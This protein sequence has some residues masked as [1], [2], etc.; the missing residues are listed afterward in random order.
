MTRFAL[1]CAALLF[2]AACD[3]DDG[4]ETTA[5]G[6]SGAASSTTDDPSTSGDDTTSTTDAPTTGGSSSGGAEGSSSGGADGSSSGG[7]SSTGEPIACDPP[8]AGE[9]NSCFD[10]NSNPT[11]KLCNWMGTGKSVGFV[12]CL[13]GPTE[14]S[15]VC[16]I[17]DCVD[18]CDCFNPPET[19]DAPVECREVLEGGGTAC[20]LNC[21]DGQT[22]P[23]GMTCDN[24]ICWHGL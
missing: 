11:P 10:E 13:T 22:C 3:D 9:W 16:M 8:V 18:A 4:G 19:G 24:G 6:S 1:G 12:G 7:S 5:A 23:D 21:G 15:N 14:G 2:I 20:V 17:R